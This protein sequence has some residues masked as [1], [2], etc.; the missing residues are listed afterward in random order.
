MVITAV[1][2]IDGVESRDTGDMVAAFINGEVRGVAQ[3]DTYL[4]GQD[5]YMA[6]LIVYSNEASGSITFKLYDNSTNT[7]INAV[8]LPISFVADGVVGGFDTPQ[9]ITDNN[10][11]TAI[12]LSNITILENQSIGTTV[13]VLSSTDADND[14]FTYSLVSGDG[15]DDNANFSIS[16]NTLK[17]TQSLNFEVKAAHNIRVRTTDSK[18]GTFEETFTI[19]LIDGND[20][21]TDISLSNDDFAENVGE[22]SLVGNLSTTDED[23]TDAYTYTLVS[24]DVAY[25]S[26]EGSQLLNTQSFNFESKS[27]YSVRIK[28]TDGGGSEFEKTFVINIVNANDAPTDMNLSP[29]VVA[30]NS[31]TGTS[32][33]ILTTTDEDTGDVFTYALAAGDGQNNNSRFIV[34]NNEIKTLD[35]FDYEERQLYYINVKVTDAGQ[36]VFT[37]LFTVQITDANDAPTAI[38]LSD[39]EIAENSGVGTEVATLFTTDPD[40]ANSHIYEL[41]TGKGSTDNSKFVISG[42]KLLSNESFDYESTKLYYIRLK[43]TDNGVPAKSLEQEFVISITD[44][45]DTPQN[46][47][48]SFNQ[49]PEDAAVGTVIGSFSVSDQDTGDSHKYA[50]VAGV[51]STDNASFVI[52]NGELRNLK[53]FDYETKSTYS[54]RVQAKDLDGDTTDAQFDIIIVNSNDEPTLLE[55]SNNQVSETSSVNTVVGKLSTVDPDGGSTFTY[56]L[57]GSGNDNS[58]FVIIGDELL[59]NTTFDYEE[60]VFYFI[61]VTSNDNEGGTISEQL[62]IIITDGNDEP[63]DITL[64]NNK[65]DENKPFNTLAGKLSTTD[66]DQTDTFTYSLVAGIDDDD[67]AFFTIAGNELQTDYMFDFESKNEFRIRL[68]STDSKGAFV[69]KNFTILISDRNDL[70]TSLDVNNKSFFENEPIGTS[71]GKLISTDPDEGDTKK[72]QLVSGENDTDN[73]KFLV[74]GNELLLNTQADFETKSF[75]NIRLAIVDRQGGTLEKAFILEVKDANDPPY[76]LELD[77]NKIAERRPVST[78]IGKLTT[79]DPDATE[80]FVYTL[81]SGYDAPSF[82]IEDDFLKANEEFDYEKKSVYTLKIA[83][84]DKEGEEIQRNFVIVVTDTNDMPSD[85]TLSAQIVEENLDSGTVV[86]LLTTVDSDGGDSFSYS[87]VDGINASGNNYFYISGNKLITAETF[88][89]ETQSSYGIRIKTIDKGGESFEKGFT[90]TIAN[91][92]DAPLSITLNNNQIK[93]NEPVGTSIGL[94]STEDK[95]ENDSHTY[96]LVGGAGDTDNA[97]FFIKNNQLLSN[98]IFDY[99]SQKTYSVLIESKDIEGATITATFIIEITNEPEPPVLSDVTFRIEEES[100]V[101]ALVGIMEAEDQD[102]STQL[103]YSIVY[104]NDEDELVEP[105]YIDEQNGEIRVNNPKLLDY[106]TTDVFFIKVRAANNANLADT[107]KVTIRLIDIIEATELPVNNYLSPN[108]DRKNDFWEIQN[109][110]LYSDFK[111][112]IFNE[113]GEVVYHTENYQNDWNGE[114]NGQQLPFGVYYYSFRNDETGIAF[115]GSITLVR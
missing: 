58:S 3:P 72:Y 28:T 32:I 92:N 56:S 35:K 40:D 33:G 103:I 76:E 8:T 12:S 5:R 16:G 4:A 44:E 70:P 101:D 104:E 110:E 48:L 68:R 31:E 87:L 54:I 64:S 60:K 91:A 51:G 112:L 15:D 39:T 9:I 89:F 1:L 14:S 108:G 106:E 66:Q 67:N 50:L 55:L 115:K 45:N 99:E 86:G 42:D 37:K 113:Y 85:I 24:G 38:E 26:I 17:T 18:G 105:F 30:E 43:T 109:V 21:P 69:E 25:F 41:V 22:G 88:D 65:V 73:A 61:D 79:S 82:Y 77:N 96:S 84:E 93:E 36:G 75:Y 98:N 27:S 80:N 102:P 94:L 59:T 90:I 34:V 62:A 57:T 7:E 46:L 100:P 49:I 29:G 71:I 107:A 19:S 81:L 114:Y 74:S 111:L 83:A 11:P 47:Q 10:L 97:S 53:Q 52:I 78:M 20:D 6:Q 23:A 13:G 63:T 95:D 2:Q